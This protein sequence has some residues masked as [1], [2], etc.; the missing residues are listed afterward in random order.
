MKQ[1]K[2]EGMQ[3]LVIDLRDNGGGLVGQAY[4]VA[5]AFLTDGQTVFTQKGRIE[6][7]TEPYSADNKAPERMPV[8][9]LVNREHCVG[10]GNTGRCFAGP[11]PGFDR[12][13]KHFRQRASCKI[14]FSSI[15]VRCCCLTIAKYETPSGRL[16]QRD[17]SN[18]D[19]YNYYT[20]GGT[21]R[22]EN[23]APIE[24]SRPREQDRRR[25]YVYS[26]GGINPDVAVKPQT[27]PSN[28]P[29]SEQAGQSDLC[30]CDG[31]RGQEE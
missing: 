17:Y 4:R 9:V 21:F 26:G 7:V 31:G 5:N 1:L 22:D 15:T 10:L 25:P 3:Q 19:L 12:R 8:V 13:R 16:I 11:R 29:L 18:G 24:P 30:I 6:G 14:R 28:G 2:A 27:I 20:E 23:S